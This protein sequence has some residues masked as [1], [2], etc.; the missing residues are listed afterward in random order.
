MFYVKVHA[1]K[2]KILGEL[3]VDSYFFEPSKYD[4][5]FYLY[6]NGERVDRGTYTENMSISFPLKNMTG[7]FLIKTFI[8]DIEYGNKRNFYSKNILIND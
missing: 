4:Y 6:K 5:A 8:R 2:N 7:S 1:E 3:I